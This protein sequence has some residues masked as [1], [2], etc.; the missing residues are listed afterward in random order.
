MWIWL[1]SHAATHQPTRD[2]AMNSVTALATFGVGRIL[3]DNVGVAA[4]R[5]D[6]SPIFPTK[7]QCQLKKSKLHNGRKNSLI[8]K[9]FSEKK[10][11]LGGT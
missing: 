5:A 6:V 7:S 2:P 9:G 10:M 3:A 1:G 4:T 8:E 11:G